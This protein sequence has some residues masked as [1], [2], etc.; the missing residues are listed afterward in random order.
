[1]IILPQKYQRPEPPLITIGWREWV[2]LPELGISWVKAK[3]DSGAKTSALHAFSLER[4]REQ[5]RDRVRFGLHPLQRNLKKVVYCTS[6]LL[7]MRW[8]S[9]S[10]GHREYRYVIQTL[11]KMGEEQWPIEITLANRDTM[12]FRMLLGRTALKDRCRINPAASY[13]TGKPKFKSKSK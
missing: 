3:V 1:M 6:D 12:L 9:D 10:S 7:D 8:V 4:V 11:I 13:C 5:G 2:R